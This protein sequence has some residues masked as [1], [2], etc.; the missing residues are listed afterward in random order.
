VRSGAERAVVGKGGSPLLI[1]TKKAVAQLDEDADASGAERD[2]GR[3]HLSALRAR[4]SR[5]GPVAGVPSAAAR[6]GL[7]KSL[8]DSLPRTADAARAK[9][10]SCG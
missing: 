6:R 3:Q 10:T 2:E 1:S 4:S 7:P 9:R 8:S 5:D